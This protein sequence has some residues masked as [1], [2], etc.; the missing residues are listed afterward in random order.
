[1]NAPSEDIKDILESI[2]SLG[3]TFG[4]NLFVGET[5]TTPD[6]CVCILDTGGFEHEDNFVYERP[7]IQ[8]SARGDKGAY[9]A[10]HELAQAVRDELHA[11]ANQTINSARYI[12][13]WLMSDVMFVGWDDNRRPEFTANFRIH[14]TTA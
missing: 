4:T 11:L 14:R 10:T 13:I 3:L 2:S 12:G 8:I 5:P 1:M 9:T 6:Q 7:T